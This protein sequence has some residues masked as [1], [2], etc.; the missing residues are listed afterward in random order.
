MQ[1]LRV[2]QLQSLCASPALE[3]PVQVLDVREPWEVELA[4]MR[5]DGATVVHIPMNEVPARLGELDAARH[6]V[7]VCHH[8]MRSAHV[9][10][11][12]ERQGFDPVY[13]LAGGIDAWAS[14]VDPTLQRY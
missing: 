13:N 9:A 4:S 12:L 7:C 11:F 14:Q 8:G 10:M 3:A 5:I 1:Q 6:V 2:D